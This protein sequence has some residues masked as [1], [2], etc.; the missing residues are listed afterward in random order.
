MKNAE[1]FIVITNFKYTNIENIYLYINMTDELSK[2][3]NIDQLVNSYN[4]KLESEEFL[5]D[6]ARKEADLPEI[7]KA[8]IL[9]ATLFF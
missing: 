7:T 4:R 6:L 2:F 8:N 5:L 9:W 1:N 3:D